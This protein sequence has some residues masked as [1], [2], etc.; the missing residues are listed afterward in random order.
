MPISPDVIYDRLIAV[1]SPDVAAWIRAHGTQVGPTVDRT[2]TAVRVF[3]RWADKQDKFTLRQQG[4]TGSIAAA[5]RDTQGPYR[6]PESASVLRNLRDPLREKIV[7]DGLILRGVMP[8]WGMTLK[9][10]RD[11][12]HGVMVPGF[13]FSPVVLSPE[14]EQVKESTE[15]M[16]NASERARSAAKDELKR[17]GIQAWWGDYSNQYLAQIGSAKG[18][19]KAAYDAWPIAER[20]ADFNTDALRPILQQV[21]WLESVRQAQNEDRDVP[22]H[23]SREADGMER[24][25]EY[26]RFSVLPSTYMDAIAATG[27][28]EGAWGDP[29]YHAGKE[30]LFNAL[31]AIIEAHPDL[32]AIRNDADILRDSGIP[33]AYVLASDLNDRINAYAKVEQEAKKRAASR[34]KRAAR[35]GYEAQSPEY[36][37][38]ISER[39]RLKREIAEATRVARASPSFRVIGGIA[40]LTAT[41]GVKL[42]L[43]EVEKKIT[44][45]ERGTA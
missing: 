6:D 42:Q 24:N 45:I 20:A 34:E 29:E 13:P 18:K 26:L 21:R 5:I 22:K 39:A 11:R 1:A 35:K 14:A 23:I 4:V 33:G 30:N 37:S 17:L 32:T 3:A 28:I 9:E 19:K 10:F 43:R 27:K 7:S 36:A 44:A 40:T 41:A 25:I 38:L 16:L 2:L 12:P 8:V 31:K 15:E